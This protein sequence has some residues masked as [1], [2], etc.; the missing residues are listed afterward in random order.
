MT[1]MSTTA[2]ERKHARLLVEAFCGRFGEWA[3]AYRLLAQHAALPLILTPE[4]VSYLRN[5][6]LRGQAPWVAESDLLLSDLCREVAYEQYVMDQAV[7]AVLIEELRRD[8]ALGKS[9]MAEVA[10]LLI[11]YIRSLARTDQPLPS[12]ELQAQQWAAMVYLDD[13]RESAA[14][15]IA[16][17]FSGVLGP[18]GA[19]RVDR[20]ELARL[21]NL[22]QALAPELGTHRE[23]VSYG[24]NVARLLGDV[25]GKAA[26]ELERNGRLDAG[27][28]VAGV[29]LPIL[30]ELALIPRV[31]SQ[32][33]EGLAYPE[34][35]QA[36]I[37]GN[38]CAFVGA[39]MSVGAGL[40]GWY[41]LIAEL[42]TRI[43]YELPPPKWTTGDAL[44]DAAQAYVNR[45]GLYSLISYLKDR[46]DI[47]GKQPTAAH[48]ALARLPISLVFTT[49]FDD[50]LERVF[51]DA[52]KRVEVV[53][54][55]KMIPFMR[56]EPDTVNI[57][58]LCGDLD[59]PDSIVL[60][61]QQYDS[62]FLQRPQM[63]EL[64]ENAV[65]YDMLYLGWGGSDPYFKMIFGELLSHFGQMMRPGYAVMFDVTDAQRDE[66]ARKQIRLVGLPAGDPTTQLAGWL[67]SLMLEFQGVE[68]EARA[69]DVKLIAQLHQLLTKRFS[70]GETP[71]PLLRFGVE[72]RRPAG[73]EQSGQGARAGGLH[74]S[75]GT[76]GRS[77]ARGAADTAG[78]RLVRDYPQTIP[79]DLVFHVVRPQTQTL[80]QRLKDLLAQ[81]EAASQ[82]LSY[83]LNVVDKLRLR[84]QLE[85]IEREIE[86]IT[87]MLDTHPLHAPALSPDQ[88]LQEL[89]AGNRR[90]ASG[91]GIHPR[92][93]P[94]RRA[95]VAPA[96]YPFALIIGCSDSR[97]PPEIIFDCGLGDLFVVRTAGHAL[98]DAGYASVQ[99]VVEHLGVQLI[100]VL[101]HS[102]CGAV[103]AVIDRVEAPGH[104]GILIARLQPAVDAASVRT[105]DSVHNAV[106]ENIRRTVAHLKALE[107]VMADLVAAGKVS[108]VG[109]FYDLETGLVRPVE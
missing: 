90:F 105:G 21:A 83:V 94:Y 82:Q 41:D 53:T 24:R 69:A 35:E 81:Y 71:Q 29:G 5:H 49:N 108:V 15:Q 50:L 100:V 20:S 64:L 73:S 78:R 30:R 11:G 107:P 89:L 59:Q 39:G 91:A 32:V 85:A 36:L 109:A 23:L 61:R 102:G 97:V 9:R 52:G 87:N 79:A 12:H 14:R 3:P 48:R 22:T 33:A 45:Q 27:V 86:R 13:K 34:L 67:E 72:L 31:V 98:D 54:G 18:G 99:Y 77:C 51:Q 17:A 80:E 62:Y 26:A 40:P 93:S 43:G 66:L 46:L 70:D 16:T 84:R 19:E 103:K 10:R 65:I 4:L 2:R 75:P 106:I 58:K 57:I 76:A 42:S 88:A 1:R 95:E 74:G 60:A 56:R 92:Q 38:V 47:T 68:P 28:Q 7:R 55:D 37:T 104:L 8:P 96:Q 63:V 6:F 25:T 44:I 101:G